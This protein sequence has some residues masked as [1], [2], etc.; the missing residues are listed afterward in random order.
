M[1]IQIE[2]PPLTRL[3]INGQAALSGKQPVQRQ[4]HILRQEAG[5]HRGTRRGHQRE[6][7]GAGTYLVTVMAHPQ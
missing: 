1:Y 2:N 6:I 3:G 4:R 5:I 7:I